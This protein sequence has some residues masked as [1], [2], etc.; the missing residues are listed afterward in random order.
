MKANISLRSEGGEEY[1]FGSVFA[2][3]TALF[4]KRRTTD[5]WLDQGD[6]GGSAASSEK[7]H[8]APLL[9]SKGC[10][11]PCFLFLASTKLG[12]GKMALSIPSL[13]LASDGSYLSANTQTS[14]KF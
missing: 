4:W 9:L 11:S 14:R 1:L 10:L 12:A 13:S 2:H 6:S 8:F 7:S 5:W 3:L